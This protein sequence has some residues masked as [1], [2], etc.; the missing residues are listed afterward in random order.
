MAASTVFTTRT[1]C[2][3]DRSGHELDRLLATQ[4]VE[5]VAVDAE[6]A[7]LARHAY[8][9]YGKGNHPAGLNFG[10]CFSYAIASVRAVPV[11][12]VGNDFAQT[13]VESAIA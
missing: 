12:F 5:I 2:Q 6:Q 4:A 3:H 10:D 7:A 1:A 8:R 13:D 11:L 9:S